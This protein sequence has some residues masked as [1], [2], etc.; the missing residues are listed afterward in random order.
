MMIPT[1]SCGGRIGGYQRDVGVRDYQVGWN[2]WLLLSSP[3]SWLDGWCA[4][5]WEKGVCLAAVRL[6]ADP[7]PLQLDCAIVET[8]LENLS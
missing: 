7:R 2:D 8:I 1:A 4:E 5:S 3:C 6:C